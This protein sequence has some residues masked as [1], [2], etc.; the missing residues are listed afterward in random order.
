M[1]LRGPKAHR[2]GL[3]EA[4]FMAYRNALVIQAFEAGTPCCLDGPEWRELAADIYEDAQRTIAGPNGRG[5]L[6]LGEDFFKE[7][8]R[9]PGALS[10]AQIVAIITRRAGG[11]RKDVVDGIVS[12]AKKHR[13]N[14]KALFH[15]F[16]YTLQKK[17]QKIREYCSVPLD[18]VFPISYVFPNI[19]TAS[20]YV[21]FWNVFLLMNIMLIG[22]DNDA[23][24][25]EIYRVENIEVARQ[26][27]KSAEFMSTSSFL[28]PFFI[29]NAQGPSSR[30]GI[31]C[32][33]HLTYAAAEMKVGRLESRTRSKTCQ[34]R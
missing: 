28:E 4:M 27:C 19:F 1:R 31:E 14:L 25:L 9:L 7:L 6:T 17:H 23:S 22:L 29:T 13:A 30:S 2:Y 26:V 15:R 11:K 24:A 32:L 8:I 10:D 12:R 5:I 21:G 33:K 20:H 3:D 16:D 18:P 34:S